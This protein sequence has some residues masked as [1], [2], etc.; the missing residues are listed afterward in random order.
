MTTARQAA[1]P[2]LAALVACSSSSPP[3]DAGPDSGL[4]ASLD[5]TSDAADSGSGDAFTGV[6]CRMLLPFGVGTGACT[7]TW[8]QCTDGRVYQVNCPG[9]MPTLPCECRIQDEA[10]LTSGNTIAQDVCNLPS[11]QWVQAINQGCGWNIAAK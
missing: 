7:F 9:G 11:S 3:L 4:D 8:D 2:L 6:A 10:G 1:F 5:A